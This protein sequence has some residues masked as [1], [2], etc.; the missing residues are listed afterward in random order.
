MSEMRT[1]LFF[2]DWGR[3]EPLWD[4][5]AYDIAVRADDLPLNSELRE[6]LYSY[7]YFWEKHFDPFGDWDSESSRKFHEKE[8]SRLVHELNEQLAGF[9]KVVDKAGN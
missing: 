5:D 4:S 1:I 8:G 9:A 2:P 6:S 7:M 3:K